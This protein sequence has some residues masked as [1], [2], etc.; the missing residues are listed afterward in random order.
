MKLQTSITPRLDGTVIVEGADGETYTFT[1]DESGDLTG[2]ISH[3]ETLANLLV[4][5]MFY[6]A[7]PADFE[8]ANEITRVA[9]SELDPEE[10]DELAADDAAD[11]AV[12]DALPVEENTPPSRRRPR[13]A[14]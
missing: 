7:D 1:P 14:L 6:P 3:P 10:R 4:R 8:A 9:E 11:E 2:E 5:G 13:K 12:S